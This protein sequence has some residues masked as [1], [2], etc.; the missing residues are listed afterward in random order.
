M[1]KI[2]III[3]LK[4]RKE[5]YSWSS[6]CGAAETNPIRNC[7][8]VGSIPGLTQWVK[9]PALL[10]AVDLMLLWLWLAAVGPTGS[11]A[12]EPPYAS[13]MALK[14]RKNRKAFF[15]K[16]TTVR[17]DKWYSYLH[18]HSKPLPFQYSPQTRNLL[19]VSRK[20]DWFSSIFSRRSS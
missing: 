8:V 3:Q 13:S 10:W 4:K 15:Q 5:K 17:H 20:R 7:E 14:K 12:R 16:W 2:K 9:D 18:C 6:H 11:L 19:M 1:E